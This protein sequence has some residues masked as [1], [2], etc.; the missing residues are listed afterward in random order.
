MVRIKFPEPQP[1]AEPTRTEKVFAAID[2]QFTDPEVTA[3]LIGLQAG[4]GPRRVKGILAEQETKLRDELSKRRMAKAEEL[5]AKT[6]FAIRYV[7]RLCGYR[8]PSTF[9]K[10]FA[11]K[12]DGLSPR[13]YRVASGGTRRAGGA[14]GAF[15]KPA[16]RAR[17]K[18]RGEPAP[19]MS[20]WR[21]LNGYWQARYVEWEDERR[22]AELLDEPIPGPPHPDWG[23]F[24]ENDPYIDAYID[25]VFGE[26]DDWFEE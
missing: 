10:R 15:R 21:T 8:C 1:A 12:H 7:A 3:R 16:Q 17:A 5:L 18:K 13:D 22:R 19:S 24:E 20:P 2:E 26:I 23:E 14:T 25:A 9:A 4:I 6:G 11:E